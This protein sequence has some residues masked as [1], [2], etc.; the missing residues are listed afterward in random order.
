MAF[1]HSPMLPAAVRGTAFDGMVHAA[2]WYLTV[3]Q[4]IAGLGFDANATGPIPLDSHNM[5]PALLAG[6][7]SPRNEVV[8][9]PLSNPSVNVHVD[10]DGK[11]CSSGAGCATSY[12][13]GQYKLIIG[14][15]GTDGLCHPLPPSSDAVPF[16]RSSGVLV[17]GTDHCTGDK[18][19]N[20]ES[21]QPA[22]CDPHCLFN[23]APGKDLSESNDLSGNRAYDPVVQQLMDRLEAL[24]PTGASMPTFKG[25]DM[26]KNTVH[27]RMCWL[28][29][30]TGFWL[31]SDWN[32]SAV[33]PFPPPHPPPPPPCTNATLAAA[34][35]LREFHSVDAC[36][37]CTRAATANGTLVGCRPKARQAYCKELRCGP[38]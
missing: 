10:G 4:G 3:T 31:P 29:Q 36:L 17:P 23:V 6:G 5:W 35:P 20:N 15:P 21:S 27:P 16:G 34:C 1:V 9:M 19:S 22:R 12:R 32:S 2:D 18:W 30:H 37:A 33:L 28:A 24:S 25:S 11:N 8:H 7:A 26:Y 38:R 13:L 14:W